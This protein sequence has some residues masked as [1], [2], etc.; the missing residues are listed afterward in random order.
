MQP[1]HLDV[2]AAYRQIP[3]HPD[4]RW[5]L[6]T[7]W[8][9]GVFFDSTL[10]WSAPNIFSAVADAAQRV[11]QMA[12]VHAVIQYLDDLL[13]VGALASDECGQHLI[14]LSHIFEQL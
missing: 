9:N 1:F 10:P 3:V 12:G 5:L 4:Y 2:Q 7:R 11:V 8:E 13:L 6:G 14:Q